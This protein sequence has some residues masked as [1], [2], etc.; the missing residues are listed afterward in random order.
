MIIELKLPSS[1]MGIAEGEI[2]RWLKAEG[3]AIVKGEVLVE[4]ETAKAVEEL[5]SPIT[6]VLK[7][8]LVPEEETA[9]VDEVLAL[10]EETGE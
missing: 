3:D 10:L 8:I 1:G 2:Q 5:E 4:V 9:E 6:G 7:K